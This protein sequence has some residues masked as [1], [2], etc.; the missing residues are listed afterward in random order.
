EDLAQETFVRV[1]RALPS[2]GEDGRLQLSS[3]ILTIS[4]RLAIDEL[5]RAG[6]DTEPL[7]RVAFRLAGG[8]PT[9]GQAERRSLAASIE[10]AVDGLSPEYRAA[11]LVREGH[12]L[13]YE[14]I[15]AA[16]S[17]APGTVKSRR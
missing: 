5:R 17:I 1:F 6:L 9:D 14:A 13:E 11:F 4:A 7:D 16:L 10:R 8:E 15:A 12:G 2:F 3:W